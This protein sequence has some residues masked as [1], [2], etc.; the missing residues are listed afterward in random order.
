MSK[1]QRLNWRRRPHAAD[2]TAASRF[3][4]LVNSPSQTR[5]LI[6]ALRRSEVAHHAAKDLLRASGLPL[7]AER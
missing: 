1:R 4:A 5:D 3:L 6:G 7:L 2:L